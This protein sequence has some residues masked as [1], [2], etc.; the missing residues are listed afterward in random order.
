MNVNLL[1][2][3]ISATPSPVSFW[4]IDTGK[5]GLPQRHTVCR[6]AMSTARRKALGYGRSVEGRFESEAEFETGAGSFSSG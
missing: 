6:Q 1:K 3:V 2:N 4:S 5:R